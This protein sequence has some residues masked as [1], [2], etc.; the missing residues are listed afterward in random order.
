MGGRWRAVQASRITQL[1]QSALFCTE[2]VPCME[3]ATPKVPSD[4]LQAWMQAHGQPWPTTSPWAASPAHP[5]G[6]QE[7]PTRVAGVEEAQVKGEVCPVRPGG[8]HQRHPHVPLGVHLP[9]VRQAHAAVGGFRVLSC[10]VQGSAAPALG[11]GAS[12]RTASERRAL[13]HTSQA[14]LPATR[15]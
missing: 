14:G 10:G 7:R 12:V 11:A 13:L 4:A 15:L 1:A 8:A 9:Q 6:W 3:V 5:P 2:N